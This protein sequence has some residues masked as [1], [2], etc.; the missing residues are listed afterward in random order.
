M[1]RNYEISIRHP[2]RSSMAER[3]KVPAKTKSKTRPSGAASYEDFVILAKRKN[4][5]T[6]EVCVKSS[7]AGR[8]KQNV[9]VA[10]S[11]DEATKLRD[12]FVSGG[13]KPSRMMITMDEASA[14]GNR[15]AHVLF[16]SP[17]FRLFA[18][19]LSMVARRSNAGLRIRLDLDASLT[20]LPWEYVS[21]PDSD[22]TGL[23]SGFLLLDASISMIR[24]NAQQ[25]IA[26]TPIK[27]QQGLSFV[28]TM[29]EGN[30]DAW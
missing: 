20:D 28:G 30:D 2:E 16:P 22:A 25:D 19:S 23:M 11:A 4:A 1:T 3:G 7:P 27:G 21:R 17:V 5:S 26:V 9:Q 18:E 29:W 14:I 13:E 10:F 8:M 15:L 12:S 24:K 6:V